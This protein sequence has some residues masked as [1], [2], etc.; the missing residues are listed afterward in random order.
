MF[1]KV[2][3]SDVN[4]KISIPGSKSHTI[5]SLFF[6]A[7][8]N[9]KSTIKNPLI[10]SD[11]ISAVNLCKSFG[12][13]YDL[14]NNCYIA[15]GVGSIPRVPENIIDVGNSGTSLRLGMMTA[16]LVQGYTVFTGDYQIRKRQ[17]GPLV[18]AI[19][20]LG[21]EAFTTRGNDSA[22]VIVKGRAAGG[23]TKLDAVTSQYLSSILIN[24][25][26]LEKDTHVEVTRLNEVPY[27]ELTLWWLDKFGIKYSHNNMKE[28]F[29]P[30][31]QQY[32]S[33]ECT[34]PGDFS[35][36][37]FFMV[38]AAI[39]G[40]EITLENL[41][42]SDPQGDKNVLAILEDMGAKVTYGKDNITIKGQKLYGRTI[43]MNA[44]PDALPAM[45]VAACFAE[46]ETRLVNV[47]Q[48]R[49]KETD[50]ISVMCTELSKMGADIKEL[51]DG[52]IIRESKLKGCNLNG[53]DDH[54]IVMSLAIAGLNSTG[55]TVIDTA[56]AM[57]VTFPSFV[58]CIKNCG[59]KIQL[60]ETNE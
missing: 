15:E 38:L 25:P 33:F 10:S 4:G 20:N 30:G 34:I 49:L 55:N 11:S 47:P 32:S 41:D 2:T 31:Q 23:F 35:S 17:V 53:H 18:Q 46:G 52:L 39:S 13:N 7:L 43:D 45:A 42:M 8:A 21:G 6:A 40:Q 1:L 50:R 48:A 57:N 26:L 59:G 27:V 37:T 9:G 22:P 29:I 56:E 36:A 51:P 54:R 16:A 19:N 5:R 28:F 12:A 3:K 58:N 44:I 60:S 24:A 14:I